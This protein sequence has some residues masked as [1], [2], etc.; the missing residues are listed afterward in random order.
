MKRHFFT[1]NLI[2][3]M[4]QSTVRISYDQAKGYT[5]SIQRFRSKQAFSLHAGAKR[6]RVTPIQTN[7]LAAP[8][9]FALR[10]SQNSKR[11][12]APSI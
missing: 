2:N 9:L 6:R 8:D 1:T 4:I 5:T 11:D 12:F 10:D 3:Y 7:E